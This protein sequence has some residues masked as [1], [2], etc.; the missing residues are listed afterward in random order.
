MKSARAPVGAFSDDDLHLVTANLDAAHYR[1]QLGDPSV[2]DDAAALHYCSTGWREGLDPSRGFSTSAYLAQYDDVRASGMN[3]FVHFLRYGSDE[4]RNPVPVIP[5]TAIVENSVVAK[6]IRRVGDE[7]DTE[8]YLNANPDVD[9][10]IINPI[11]HYFASGAMEGRDPTPDFSTSYYLDANPDVLTGEVNPF[12]HYI[13]SGRREGRLPRK[14]G[15]FRA[16]LLKNLQPLSR[17]LD[18]WKRDLSDIE[19]HDAESLF[20]ALDERFG[21]DGHRAILAFGHDD[22]TTVVGGLQF[23][24]QSEQAEF[25]LLGIRYINLHPAQPLP[26]LAEAG[27]A[28][29]PHLNLLIDGERIGTSKSTDICDAFRRLRKAGRR[30]DLVVHS[31]HGHAPEQVVRIA[32]SAAVDNAVYW[33]H[34]YF[35]LCAAHTL[36][37]NDISYC[38]APEPNSAAC[39]ICIHGEEREKHVARI[40]K[41]F[42]ALDFTVSAPSDVAMALWESRS[43]LV[44][45]RKVVHRHCYLEGQT[46]SRR[47]EQPGDDHQLRVAFIGFPTVHKGW[48]AFW[49][50]VEHLGPA[51]AFAFYHIGAGHT[52]DPRVQNVAVSVT[53]ANPTAMIDAIWDNEIDLVVLWSLWPETF[54][55][56]AY[57]ALAGGALIVTH[58]DSGNIAAIVEE[59][60]AGWVLDSEDALIELLRSKELREEVRKRGRRGQLTGALKYSRFTA[61]LI[62]DKADDGSAKQGREI[63]AQ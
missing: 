40:R 14:P 25:E 2:G 63:L 6:Q 45:N 53:R 44:A 12:Y 31:L 58:T 49:M 56:T 50:G 43:G 34:D 5:A 10:E 33:V 22:Y 52:D 16:D 55:L 3:P 28:G 47:N 20:T 42:E 35:S 41:M 15:G 24:V 11:A 9:P 23:V 13:V 4:G 19:L 59:N 36:L 1:R 51:D 37:R 60:A 48:P 39:G 57:E 61:D 32:Q 21:I 30:F 27:T 62:T 7:F 17:R 54:S 46:R 18:D 8:F 26:V 38:G 29:E